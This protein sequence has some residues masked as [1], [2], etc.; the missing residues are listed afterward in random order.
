MAKVRLGRVALFRNKSERVQGLI[1]KTGAAKMRQA[2]ARIVKL[3][4]TSMVVSDADAIEFLARGEKES[5]E[6]WRKTGVIDET[7]S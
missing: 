5:L 6:Y 1:T 7:S 3:T 4:G 2:K